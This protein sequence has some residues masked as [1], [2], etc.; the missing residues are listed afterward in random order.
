[1]GSSSG[2]G[3]AVA[4]IPDVTDKRLV[5]LGLNALARAHQLDYFVDG[6]RGASLVA[7]HFLCVENA[8]DDRAAARIVKLFDMNWGSQPL[9]EPFHD[10]MPEPASVQK[11]GDALLEGGDVL[12][13]VGHNAIFAMLAIK[14]FRLVPSAATPQ[15]IDGVCALIRSFKPWRDMRP[16][17]HVDPPPFSD[18]RAASRFVLQE[19]L[20]A[21]DR[22]VGYGQGFAGHMLTFGQ[23]LV[24]LAA[25]GEGELAE[26]CRTAFRKYVTVTRRGPEPDARRIADHK[27]SS[28][29]PREATYW[30]RRGDKAV[31]MGHV[32]KYP[33]SYYDLLR[34]ANDEELT[35]NF[36]EKAYHLF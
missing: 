25:M 1:L 15:R 30:E 16:D 31:D 29:R 12:R 11:I 19:A 10:E 14:A 18:S 33:Y 28:L 8:L 24:E 20:A 23:A 7:A 4:E 9:C 5:L 22:F 21:I 36:E 26:T 34:R 3:T 27:P 17:E 2:N 35:Q 13:E 6:H 32:F